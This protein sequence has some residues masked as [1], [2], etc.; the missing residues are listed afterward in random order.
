MKDRADA[1]LRRE[2]AAYLDRLLPPREALLAEM[3]AWSAA[4][5]V[6][7]SDPE[8]GKLLSI[9]A[10]SR[11]ARRILEVG[12]AIGYG[13]LCLARGAP[14][15]RV[16]TIDPDA[17]RREVA[18]GFLARAGVLERVELIDGEA[19]Q[20]LPRLD[21]P[22]DLVYVDALKE[23]YRRYLDLALPK[24]ALG[25]LVV[26][27]NVLWKGRVAEPPAEQ[28]RDA[29]AIRAFNGYLMIHPQLEA[30]VLPLGDGVGLAVKTKT[31]IMEMGGPF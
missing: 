16:L 2:Q 20:V 19:L 26:V 18:R 10:R 24:M 8:V 9:L 23:E 6:P 7:S 1:I 22:F 4:H 5:D 14:E 27:D 13:T 15:A 11:G 3:E 25:G 30:V 12:T 31:T 28:D 21:G 17:E 29:D